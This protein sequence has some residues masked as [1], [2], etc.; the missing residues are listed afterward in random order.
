MLFQLQVHIQ[1]LRFPFPLQQQHTGPQLLGYIE[2]G[3]IRQ[4]GLVF[5]LGQVQHI[6]GHQAQAFAFA[7]DNVQVLCLL[8]GVQ[9][10]LL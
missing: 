4:N 6:G 1:T 7:F 5:H 9:V 2:G 10:A 3:H 8:L